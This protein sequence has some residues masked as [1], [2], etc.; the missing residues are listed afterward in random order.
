MRPLPVDD[1]VVF[2]R[3]A[4][5][6]ALNSVTLVVKDKAIESTVSIS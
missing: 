5:Q 1:V 6:V 3:L 2:A 4:M